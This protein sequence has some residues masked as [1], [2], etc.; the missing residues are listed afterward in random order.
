MNNTTTCL[1]VLGPYNSLLGTYL[2]G[3]YMLP[4]ITAFSRLINLLLNVNRYLED[5]LRRVECKCVVAEWVC[6]CS[7]E[8]REYNTSM[9]GCTSASQNTVLCLLVLTEDDQTLG[10]VL[11]SYVFFRGTL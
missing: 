4:D 11:L 10:S 9:S 6:E 8:C 1:I 7:Q 3:G 5:E 2:Q